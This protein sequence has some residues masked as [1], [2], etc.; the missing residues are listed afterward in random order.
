MSNSIN[1]HFDDYLTFFSKTI[2]HLTSIAQKFAGKVQVVGITDENDENMVKNFVD[3]MG[4]KMEYTV[5]IDKTGQ[6]YNNYMTAYGIG[7]IPHAFVVDAEGQIIWNDHPAQPSLIQTLEKAIIGLKPSVSKSS[8]KE[9]L[10]KM[11]EDLTKLSVKELKDICTEHNLNYSTCL[12]KQ[13]FIQLI[14]EIKE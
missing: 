11:T 4:S 13:D 2:P 7:G 5:A 10:S 9:S 6:V 8:N 1:F 12:E 14:K 3:K